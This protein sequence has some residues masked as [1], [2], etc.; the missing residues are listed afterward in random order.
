MAV[1]RKTW[2]K[3][4]FTILTTLGLGTLTSCYG[5]P[6]TYATEDTPAHIEGTVT[7]QD[8][9]AIKGIKVT[10][11]NGE[12]ELGSGLTDEDGTYLVEYILED[13]IESM[14]FTLIYEDVD[15]EENGGFDS[16]SF[17]INYLDWGPDEEINIKLDSKEA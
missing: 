8:G 12:T 7:S 1:L 4:T 14:D 3:V 13:S 16:K 10:L 15:G 6:P 5:M 2:K 17:S 9:T 11:K